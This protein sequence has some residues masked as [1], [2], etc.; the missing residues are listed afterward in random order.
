M[1]RA[2]A[3]RALVNQSAMFISR[4]GERMALLNGFYTFVPYLC[5]RRDAVTLDMTDQSEC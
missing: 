4:S 3:F 5:G 2:S 1:L